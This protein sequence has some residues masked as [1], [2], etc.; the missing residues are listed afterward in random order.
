MMFYFAFSLSAHFLVYSKMNINYL[1]HV[2][3]FGVS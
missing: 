2:K 1:S 3:K